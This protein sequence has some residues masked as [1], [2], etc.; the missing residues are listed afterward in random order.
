MKFLALVEQLCIRTLV[1]GEE[2]EPAKPTSNYQNMTITWYKNPKIKIILQANLEGQRWYIGQ[3]ICQ[4]GQNGLCVLTRIS[5]LA[6]KKILILGFY[7]QVIVIFWNLQVSFVGSYSSPSMQLP[8]YVCNL[9]K[10][11]C[12]PLR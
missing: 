1:L 6:Y 2:N 8:Y 3:K 12:L 10:P 7:Y 11:N 5:K 4:I 9:G